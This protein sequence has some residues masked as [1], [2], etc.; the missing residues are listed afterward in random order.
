MIS[1]KTVELNLTTEFINWLSHLSNSPYFAVGPT[2]AQ[3]AKWGFDV[4][5]FGNATGVLIQYK[6]AYVNG[7]V[8]KWKLNRTKAKD[9]L[10]LLQQLEAA[11]HTVYYAFPYFHTI[12]DI[13]A[14]RRKL[15]LHTFWF[16]PSQINPV[17]GP[18]GH[19]EVCFDSVTGKWTVHSEEG[20]D[21]PQPGSIAEVINGIENPENRLSS[22]AE[23]F[24]RIVLGAN[25]PLDQRKSE[26][27]HEGE[28][29]ILSGTC[30]VGRGD[31]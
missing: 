28:F 3:E 6:R 18:N 7:S 25:Q 23:D 12:S 10:Y 4:G 2:Q 5:V 19:H 1:E 9:Q 16:K 13:Q 11:G 20:T 31:A 30:I 15:L 14:H 26:S 8:W 17:G 27:E 24:N 29:S 21:L 22:L